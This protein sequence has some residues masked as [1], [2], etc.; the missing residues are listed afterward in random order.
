MQ[1]WHARNRGGLPTCDQIQAWLMQGASDNVDTANND[2]V[3]HTGATFKQV[4][5]LGAL[6]AMIGEPMMS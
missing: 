3:Q 1:E 6:Q 2:N 4:D 5:A